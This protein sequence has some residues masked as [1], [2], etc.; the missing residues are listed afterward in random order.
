MLARKCG[1]RF[2]VDGGSFAPGACRNCGGARSLDNESSDVVAFFDAAH[3]VEL[4]FTRVEGGVNYTVDGA[5][6]PG[7]IRQV[8]FSP[9]QMTLRF[10]ET[11]KGATLPYDEAELDRLLPRLVQLFDSQAVDH[12]VVSSLA[13]A[14]ALVGE[15]QGQTWRDRR[16]RRVSASQPSL[17]RLETHCR[18]DAL[19]TFNVAQIAAVLEQRETLSSPGHSESFDDS[20]LGPASAASDLCESLIIARIVPN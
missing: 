6:R 2:L 11:G 20:S 10:P 18:C 3:G 1:A 9:R 4:R 15:E 13:D 12:A 19:A 7:P 17:V 16:E 14:D 5:K 8:E